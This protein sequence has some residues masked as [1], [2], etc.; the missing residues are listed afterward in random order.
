MEKLVEKLKRKLHGGVNEKKVGRVVG[1]RGN[2]VEGCEY[3]SY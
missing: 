3:E 2:K 1:V